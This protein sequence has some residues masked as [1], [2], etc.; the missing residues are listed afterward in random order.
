MKTVNKLTRL[1]R[2]AAVVDD[3]LEKLV[4]RTDLDYLYRY[5]FWV[6]LLEEESLKNMEVDTAKLRVS[7]FMEQLITHYIDRRH[8]IQMIYDRYGWQ[9]MKR[10]DKDIEMLYRP[11]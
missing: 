10:Q 6:G 4:T 7:K 2:I 9:D 11:V 8:K 5:N 1:E 3:T